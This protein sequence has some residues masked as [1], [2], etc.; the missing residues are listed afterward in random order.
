[1]VEAG[2]FMVFEMPLE[3]GYIH[4]PFL[5]SLPFKQSR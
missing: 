3:Q 1:M 4:V 2:L 5:F